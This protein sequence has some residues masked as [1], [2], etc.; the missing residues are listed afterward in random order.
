MTTAK[1]TVKVSTLNKTQL[2]AGTFLSGSFQ[3][4]P[5]PWPIIHYLITGL[6]FGKAPD[7]IVL[8]PRTPGARYPDQFSVQVCEVASDYLDILTR[9]IDDFSGW[10]LQLQ[11]DF[12]IVV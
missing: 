4:G 2:G 10:S 9:R 1:R 12:Q 8:T 6:G 11:I 5:S 7:S 3:A